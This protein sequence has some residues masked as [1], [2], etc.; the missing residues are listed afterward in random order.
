MLVDNYP[1]GTKYLQTARTY[2]ETIAAT[3]NAH[4]DAKVSLL[5]F[6]SLTDAQKGCD[7][8]PNAVA[9]AGMAQT[10]QA[11]LNKTLGW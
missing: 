2:L 5:V 11:A 3:A 6:D 8:H 4:G 1:Q 7:S 10:L 9:Q